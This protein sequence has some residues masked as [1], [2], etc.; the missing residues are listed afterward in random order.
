MTLCA[1]DILGANPVNI[2]WNVVRGDTATLRIDFLEDDEITF[3]DISGW[4]IEATAYE[5]KTKISYDL[6]ITINDGWI[7][8][9]ADSD[10]TRRWGEGTRYRVNELNFDV[11]VTLPDLAVWTP[12]IG[13]VSLIADVTGSSL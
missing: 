12:V 8:V 2:Q 7:V 9:T 10:D 4:V 11:E 3:L 6:G 13:V 1:R 5:S